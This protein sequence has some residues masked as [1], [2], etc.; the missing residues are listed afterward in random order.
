MRA[1]GYAAAECNA[2]KSKVALYSW[3][4]SGSYDAMAS[5]NRVVFSTAQAAEAAGYRIAHNCLYARGTGTQYLLLC[6]RY[7]RTS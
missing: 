2:M 4:G 5:R 7:G 3:P 6:C 1:A